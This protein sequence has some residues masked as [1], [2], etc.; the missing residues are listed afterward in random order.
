MVVKS[1]KL[2]FR[3]K[4][5]FYSLVLIYILI[6][7]SCMMMRMN[8][9][10]TKAFF[11]PSKTE[12][13][14]KIFVFKGNNMHYIETGNEQKPTLF[15]VHGSPGSWDVFRDY[16]KDSLLLKN[17]RM[18]AVDRPGFGY[19]NFG[20]AEDLQIQAEHIST[21]LKSIDNQKPIALIGHSLGGPVIVKMATLE[22]KLYKHLFILA[23]S[24]DPKA[25]EPEKW[26]KYIMKK[27]IR[28]LIPGALLPA[29]D[30]L[31]WLKHDLIEMMPTL[32]NIVSNITIIHGTKDQ[33]VPYS[34]VA[35]I[36]KEFIN[37][38][39]IKTISIKNANHFIPWEHYTE[40]R[41]ALLDLKL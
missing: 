40:I 15:F 37:A 24:I 6:C 17:F 5:V 26:R 32:K 41:D 3:I 36:Q 1:L 31:W 16:L 27:P 39:S 23:G 21:F 14:D 28:Y 4:Y 2:K 38:K 9:K 8:S 12:Y 34:N 22:P 29:N 19:S 11:A 25:E 10:E 20:H 35:F 7:Q 18:I 33:L 13:I 30:E